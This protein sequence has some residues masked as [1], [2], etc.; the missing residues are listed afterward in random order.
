MNVYVTAHGNVPGLFLGTACL[1]THSRS[2][3]KTKWEMKWLGHKPDTSDMPKEP[4]E[5]KI[6][7]DIG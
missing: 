7:M 5:Y 3:L 4:L 1:F 2:I 6:S